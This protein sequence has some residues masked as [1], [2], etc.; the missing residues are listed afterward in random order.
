MYYYQRI[1]ELRKET[2]ESQNQ[3]AE[4]LE[5]TRQQYALYENGKR[6]MPTHLIMILAK[7]YNT[8]IDY[9]VGLTDIR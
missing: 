9:I 2:K 5:I 4:I 1:C 7:H 8:S 6:E 3:I